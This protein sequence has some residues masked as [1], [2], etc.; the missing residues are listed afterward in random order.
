MPA[1]GA[2]KN[3]DGA[4]TSPPPTQD[5]GFQAVAD[6]GNGTVESAG[7]QNV[8]LAPGE[9]ETVEFTHKIASAGVY[10]VRIDTESE[11]ITVTKSK[12]N[13][14]VIAA[15]FIVLAVLGGIGYVLISSAPEGGWTVEKLADAIKEL[16]R[17]KGSL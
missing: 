2:R 5:I 16:F 17:K 1:G 3:Q 7:L 14:G 12:S 11:E 13:S 15:I 9:V 4:Q 10:T 8:T 6:D